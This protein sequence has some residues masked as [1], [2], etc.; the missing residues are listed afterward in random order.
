[1]MATMV[2]I[3]NFYINLDNVTRIEVM[4][5]D[6]RVIIFFGGTALAAGHKPLMMTDSMTLRGEQG[7]RLLKW[8]DAGGRVGEA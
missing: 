4:D 5:E 6:E 1:M 7:A 3:D 8:L 2:R